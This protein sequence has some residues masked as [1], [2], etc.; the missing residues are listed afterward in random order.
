MADQDQPHDLNQ[1]FS[2]STNVEGSWTLEMDRIGI[3]PSLL[4]HLLAMWSWANFLISLL[5]QFPYLYEEVIINTEVG[6]WGML[7][8]DLA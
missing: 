6:Y 3:R 4:C 1:F 8:E 5:V 2:S 7:L